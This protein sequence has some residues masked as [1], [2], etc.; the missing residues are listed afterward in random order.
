MTTTLQRTLVLV[1]PDGVER[2]LTGEILGRIER[3]GYRLV[4]LRWVRPSRELLERHYAEHAGKPFFEPLVEFMLTGPIVAAVFEGHEVIAGVRSLL[5][6][7]DPTVAAPGTIRGDLGRDWG[8]AVQR[9]LVH[10]SDSPE[11]AAREIGIWFA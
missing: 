2:G 3:K 10:A 8:V 6:A 4:D 7:S 1:K 9:N 11:S 5:G